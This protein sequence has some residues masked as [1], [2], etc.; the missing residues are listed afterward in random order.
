MSEPT[1]A[2]PMDVLVAQTAKDIVAA[3]K[4]I[5]LDSKN[6]EGS[7]VGLERNRKDIKAP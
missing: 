1:L 5:L 4:L 2:I 6:R 3:E 7:R